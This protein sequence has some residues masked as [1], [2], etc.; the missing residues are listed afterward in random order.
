MATAQNVNVYQQAVETS[1]IYLGPAGERFIR[2]QIV[3]HLK[4]EPEELSGKHIDE[5]VSWVKITFALLTDNSKYVHEFASNLLQLSE[6]SG[7]NGRAN[8]KKTKK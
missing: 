4:I 1:K 6:A 2:R 7:N 8:G 5:L 3:T